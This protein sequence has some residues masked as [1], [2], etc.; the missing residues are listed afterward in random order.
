MLIREMIPQYLSKSK[1]QDSDDEIIA[2]VTA[3]GS[4]VASNDE[5]VCGFA[6]GC[7]SKKEYIFQHFFCPQQGLRFYEE[8]SKDIEQPTVLF[9]TYRNPESWSK[10]SGLE[11]RTVG[12]L[13]EVVEGARA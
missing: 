12:F 10:A 1:C 8:M 5:R 3:Q 4:W 2:M 11:M 13:C 9:F 6:V 7:A